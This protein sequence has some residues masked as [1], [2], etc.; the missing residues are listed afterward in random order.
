MFP[1]VLPHAGGGAYVR[2]YDTVIGGTSHR[3]LTASVLGKWRA[4]TGSE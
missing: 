3:R 2:R 4:G 1:A